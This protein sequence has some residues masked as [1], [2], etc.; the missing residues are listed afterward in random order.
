ASA[1]PPLLTGSPT[2]QTPS[3]CEGGPN[4]SMDVSPASLRTAARIVEGAADLADAIR[5]AQVLDELAVLPGAAETRRGA[6]A[7]ADRWHDFHRDLVRALSTHADNLV[8][9]AFNLVK[10]D[11]Q[12]AL[13]LN[14]IQP[15][16]GA[17]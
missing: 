13:R 11:E 8:I 16:G 5:P 12:A 17:T 2:V 4:S 15:D 9:M 14:G 3:R 7:L 1:E 10:A 6:G